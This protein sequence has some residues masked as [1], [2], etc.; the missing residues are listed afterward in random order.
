MQNIYNDLVS[1]VIPTYNREKVIK[2][3]LNSILNQTYKNLEVIVVDDASIDDTEHVVRSIKDSRLKYIRLNENSHGTKP[4]NIGIRA[5]TGE[6]IA[7]LDSDDTWLPNKIERQ[8]AFM[9]KN[10]Y[11]DV[12]SFT[13]IIVS[14][15]FTQKTVIKRDLKEGEHIIDYIINEGWVQCGTFMCSSKIAKKT[16]FSPTVRKH[17]DWDFCYRL[18][19]NNA[20]FI[21][22][23]EAL[24][25]YNMDEGNNQISGN[26]RFDL[27]LKW[28]NSIKKDI[29]KKNY[30]SFLVHNVTTNMILSN[31][32]KKALKIYVRALQ[33]RA[34]SPWGFV[35]GIL[36]CMLLKHM[37]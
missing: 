33:N 25:V 34:V 31:N 14:N 19:K 10:D 4:R 24:T 26:R 17:Q 18:S 3:C 28:I 1:V 7:F 15:N 30:Y 6:Y 35:K 22:L 36:K 5:A 21:Y 23:E 9:K 27:S 16:E 29:S 32:R 2:Q 12:L 8:L 13:G 37:N 11:T 20:R